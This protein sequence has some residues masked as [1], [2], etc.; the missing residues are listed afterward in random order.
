MYKYANNPF[1]NVALKAHVPQDVHIV[2]TELNQQQ[3]Q[4]G[5]GR[6]NCRREV[7]TRY[8]NKNTDNKGRGNNQETKSQTICF[9]LSFSASSSGELISSKSSQQN[10]RNNKQKEKEKETTG[11]NQP[12]T[13]SG[14]I[15]RVTSASNAKDKTNHTET[16]RSRTK[17][18][19]TPKTPEFIVFGGHFI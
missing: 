19:S 16:A 5:P 11:Q 10:K 13:V 4:S 17:Q 8:E 1:S 15:P 6:L 14:K 9:L 18:Q 3:L 2:Y 7:N 12:Y